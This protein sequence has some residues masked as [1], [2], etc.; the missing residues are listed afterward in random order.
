MKDSTSELIERLG[1]GLKPS[2]PRALDGRVAAA[3]AVGAG[4]AFVLLVAS[5]GLRPDL[6]AAAGGWILWGKLTY[7]AALAA[8]G[9]VLCLQA[10]RPAA[11]PSWRIALVVLPVAL[12][13]IAALLRVASL[14]AQ[15]RGTD[16]LGETAAICPWLIGAL[17]LPC[18][19][20]LTVVMRRA[21]PTR[22]RWAGFCAG[23]LAGAIS[24]LVYSLHCPE[25]G[26]AFVATWYT[27]GMC[28]PAAVGAVFGRRL[29]RW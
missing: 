13:G 20:A 22:L 11:K 18:L 14:P 1:T 27:L 3:L 4:A 9:Y 25:T 24:M 8:G 17:S 5:L 15:V 26:V 2:P 7:A 21:A 16:W 23:L 10:A 29:L 12:A 6:A 19:L 28:V